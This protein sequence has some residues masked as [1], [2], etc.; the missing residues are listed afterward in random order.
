MALLAQVFHIGPIEHDLLQVIG[1]LVATVLLGAFA[2]SYLRSVTAKRPRLVSMLVLVAM[3][4]LVWTF[5]EAGLRL[6]HAV[7]EQ[8]NRG[9]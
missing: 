3:G 5:A 8:W 4:T 1:L 7:M 9:L 6:C 2:F